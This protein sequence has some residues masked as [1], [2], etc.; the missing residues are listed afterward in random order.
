MENWK[1]RGTVLLAAGLLCWAAAL[2]LIGHH[3][4]DERRASSQAQDVVGGFRSTTAGMEEMQ[5]LQYPDMEMPTVE[6]DGQRYIGLLT[7]PSLGLQLP[8]LNSL[9]DEKLKLAPCRYA[10]SVYQDSLIVAAHNYQ[11]HFGRLKELSIGDQLSFLDADGNTFFYQVA[12]FEV[13][14]AAAVDE[15]QAGDWDFTLFTCTIGGQNR[16][17]VRCV[18]E[19]LL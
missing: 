1:K 16:I 18:R 8:V 3:I 13:L 11:S 6:I 2:L 5:Y 14:P 9:D 7:M 10:G 12:D 19:P 4:W 15:M 17:A